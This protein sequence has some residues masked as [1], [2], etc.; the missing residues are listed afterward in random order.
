MKCWLAIILAAGFCVLYGADPARELLEAAVKAQR[1][2]DL[3]GAAAAYREALE[4]NPKLSLAH[5]LLG[6]CELQLGNTTEG[7]RHL[8]ILRRLDP[9]NRQ[10]TYTLLSSYI[11]IGSLDQ[12]GKLIAVFLR[13]DLSATGMFLRGSY[14][15]ALGEYAKG[16]R[17]FQ[18]ARRLDSKLPGLSSQLG[19]T[20]CFANRLD[21]A[22]PHLE[23][24]LKENPADSNATAFLGWLYK[25]RDRSAEAATLLERAVESR[26]DDKGALFLLAQLAQSRRDWDRALAILEKVVLMDPSHR[27]AHVL[28]ARLYQQM[29]RPDD[30]AR[31]RAIVERLNAEVQALQPKAQ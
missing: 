24:A 30:A 1:Q 25:E 29:K 16:I 20:Y 19:I 3:K 26:P 27:A 28:L 4:K 10:A 31:E 8:E 2:G 23:A 12:A 21:E 22:V 6:V 18:A 5:H 14:A 9:A 17:D 13:G 7:I 15:M 11:A